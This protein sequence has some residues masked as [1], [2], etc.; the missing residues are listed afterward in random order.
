MNKHQRNF[1]DRLYRWLGLFTNFYLILI[2]VEFFA[3]LHP[4][5]PTL[6]LLLDAFAEPYLGALAVYTVLKELRK[7]RMEVPT[8][9]HRGEWFVAA[10]IILLVLTT[11]AVAVTERYHFDVAYKLIISAS[12]ASLMIYF[13]SRVHHP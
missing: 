1:I 13:G 7:R 3:V 12:L 11:I 5:Y 8:S 9:L 2:A 6:E 4:R 10:W